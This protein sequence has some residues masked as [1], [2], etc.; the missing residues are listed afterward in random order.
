MLRLV[1]LACLL[2][3]VAW[4]QP[5]SITWL[6]LPSGMNYKLIAA[7]D[8][9]L[10][11][12]IPAILTADAIATK[13]MPQVRVYD[14]VFD[15]G[16]SEELARQ[17]TAR[18][19]PSSATA[20]SALVVSAAD[21]A[22]LPPGT[23]A[24][25]IQVGA[26]KETKP[27]LLTLSLTRHPAQLAAPGSII[28]SKVSGW[29]LIGDED[30]TATVTLR[31]SSNKAAVSGLRF[32]DVREAMASGAQ[33]T[34]KI[35]VDFAP[36]D[37]ATGGVTEATVRTE[38]EFPLGTSKGKLDIVSPDLANAVSVGYE[39]RTRRG[40]WTIAFF[41]AL[42]ALLG[43][44]VRIRTAE[45]S[46]LAAARVS[47]SRAIQL[48]REEA[49]SSDDETYRNSLTTLRRAM[50][51]ELETAD[52]AKITLAVKTL[53][54]GF[55]AERS[56]LQAELVRCA[57]QADKLKS[58]VGPAWELPNGVGQAVKQ[59]RDAQEEVE[60]LLERRNAKAAST[61]LQRITEVLLPALVNQAT[62]DGTGLADYV[63]DLRTMGPP[64]PETVR[65]QVVSEGELARAQF[66]A[67]SETVRVATPEEA[68]TALQKI[69]RQYGR[70]RSLAGQLPL[71]VDN[72]VER[73]W[74]RLHVDT[75]ASKE[76]LLRL[77]AASMS[78]AK[79]IGAD[80]SDPAIGPARLRARA[81]QLRQLWFDGFVAAGVTSKQEELRQA[82]NDGKWSEAVDL[83]ANSLAAGGTRMSGGAT[84]AAPSPSAD[85]A[86]RL[87][88]DSDRILSAVGGRS[89]S[90]ELPPLVGSAG[91]RV[92][93]Y[94]FIKR[95]AALQSA[96]FAI[97]FIVG[98]YVFY[99]DTWVGTN[100]ELLGIFVLGFGVDL[101]SERVLALLKNPKAG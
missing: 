40:L 25:T 83:A 10:V 8:G 63:V 38:G 58:V 57:A 23:Y 77:R 49:E 74:A 47:A 72:F 4:A 14:A 28:L 80:L 7:S 90:V 89:Q 12:R 5:K 11:A 64:L 56:K 61:T 73:E 6:E 65:A 75:P 91:E 35:N 41:A 70:A 86:N 1:A 2:P 50:D 96:F 33:P 44:W 22:K 34:G 60:T 21:A 82:L 42:G 54:D 81:A 66:P 67:G 97:L 29:R 98:V 95:S 92:A 16:R 31:E 48:A 62:N 55:A 15:D 94:G 99:A 100:Q 17:F 85:L 27:Q 71:I 24:L 69:D 46:A 51:G 37:V 53:E 3:S 78:H 45:A 36:R 52:P 19:T 76:A 18:F 93:L 30:T 87:D 43:W 59:L 13:A 68:S 20:A 9:R 101:T 79:E 26:D 84:D 39:V 88:I 32:F